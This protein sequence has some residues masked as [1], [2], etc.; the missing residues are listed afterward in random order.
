MSTGESWNGIMHDT[1]ER[2]RCYEITH[3]QTLADC[4]NTCQYVG[5]GNPLLEFLTKDDDYTNRCGQHPIISILYFCTFVVMCAFLLLNLVIAVIIG[6]FEEASIDYMV[7]KDTVRN[8]V[9]CW[10]ELDPKA[11]H[12]ID[13][14][15]IGELVEMLEPP[16][17]VKGSK[18]GAGT[19]GILTQLHIVIRAKKI[20][21][22]ETLHALAGRVSAVKLPAQ[23]ENKVYKSLKSRLPAIPPSATPKYT[24]SQYYAAV[25]V[26]AA[27]RGF[28]WR[29]D[30]IEQQETSTTSSPT[31]KGSEG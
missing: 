11:T 22:L 1:M 29:V 20:H 6:N 21:F 12:Y 30:W 31:K 7:N 5:K 15:Q 4:Q 10:K 19:D 18:D 13:A 27:I 8:F 3:A 28:L 9:N 17:G 2:S 24:V 26:Q 14:E 25:Y 16:L 23:T